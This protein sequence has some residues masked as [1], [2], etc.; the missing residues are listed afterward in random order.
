MIGTIRED[1]E[2][3]V[4]VEYV[5]SDGSLCSYLMQGTSTD[6]SAHIARSVKN[7]LDGAQ[8]SVMTLRP[9]APHTVVKVPR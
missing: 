7:A 2:H 3:N 4:H 8:T 5:D 6:I 9:V 1:Y